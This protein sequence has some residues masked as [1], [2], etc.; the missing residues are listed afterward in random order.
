M[1]PTQRNMCAE[2]KYKMTPPPKQKFAKGKYIYPHIGS[3]PWLTVGHEP[4]TAD[5]WSHVITLFGLAS[6]VIN[7]LDTG[8]GPSLA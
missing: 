3:N 6:L 7:V 8:H 5:Q 4:M 2:G 1:T